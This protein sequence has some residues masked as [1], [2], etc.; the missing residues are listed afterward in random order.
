MSTPTPSTQ[1]IVPEMAPLVLFVCVPAAVD[2]CVPNLCGNTTIYPN[3]NGT[4]FDD[5]APST[6]FSCACT[7]GYEWVDMATG[8]RGKRPQSQKYHIPTAVATQFEPDNIAH[9]RSFQCTGLGRPQLT[10]NKSE[11]HTQVLNADSM[12]DYQACFSGPCAVLRGRCIQHD[13]QTL[14][15]IVVCAASDTG[16]AIVLQTSM[17]VLA[18]PAT[19]RPPTGHVWMQ[20]PP[21]LPTA[22]HA[23]RATRGTT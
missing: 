11:Q 8:C 1:T 2:G 18:S 9:C 6:G 13:N 23:G 7:K 10:T 16:C 4:C 5:P 14:V 21:A 12:A 17:V 3:S 22:V 20:R 19:P 15:S